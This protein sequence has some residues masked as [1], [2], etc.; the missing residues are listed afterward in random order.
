VFYKKINGEEV[1]GRSDEPS[2]EELEAEL[3][4]ILDGIEDESN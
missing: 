2:D 3:Q 4:K 1:T